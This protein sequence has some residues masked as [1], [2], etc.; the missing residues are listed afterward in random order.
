[1]PILANGAN[2]ST[3]SKSNG[4]GVRPMAVQVSEKFGPTV[5]SSKFGG[6]GAATGYTQSTFS[7]K[8]RVRWCWDYIQRR[9]L[10]LVQERWTTIVESFRPL[11]LTWFS[12][13]CP[14]CWA[15]L[16]EDLQVAKNIGLEIPM[17]SWKKSIF[18][19]IMQVEDLCKNLL[20][21]WLLWKKSHISVQI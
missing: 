16:I 3:G 4:H 6:G 5:N 13:N 14:G 2:N 10:E 17:K 11:P 9:F 1:M 20:Q 12:P 19:K 8:G 15:L 7:T 21:R 18:I